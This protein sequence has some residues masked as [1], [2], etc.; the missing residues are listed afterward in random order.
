M[1]KFLSE[2]QGQIVDSLQA[3]GAL[4]SFFLGV[5][6]VFTM[7]DKGTVMTGYIGSGFVKVG[8]TVEVISRDGSRFKV[9]VT[10]LEKDHKLIEVATK[11]DA[12]G[13]LVPLRREGIVCTG[14]LLI[15]IDNM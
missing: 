7:P 14:D 1:S 3:K 5:Q 10:G 11:G 4:V 12:I 15:K 9:R 8:D 13:I 2:V 6:D